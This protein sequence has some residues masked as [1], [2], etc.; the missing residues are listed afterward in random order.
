MNDKEIKDILFEIYS[1]GF[2]AGYSQEIDIKSAFEK[3]YN[4]LIKDGANG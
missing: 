2:E 3:Y 1:A 4:L